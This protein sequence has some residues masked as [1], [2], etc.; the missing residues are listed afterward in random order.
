MYFDNYNDTATLLVVAK[1]LADQ[2]S[3]CEF[4]SRTHKSFMALSIDYIRDRAIL[5]KMKA[6]R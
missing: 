6:D 2:A 1:H 4:V 3:K 5:R